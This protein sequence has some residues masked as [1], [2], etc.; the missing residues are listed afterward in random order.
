[1]TTPQSIHGWDEL[2]KIYPSAQEVAEGEHH[3]IYIPEFCLRPNERIEI[4]LCLT[5][6]GGYPTRLYVKNPFPEKGQ[7]WSQKYIRG[8]NWHTF[9]YGGVNNT[10]PLMDILTNHAKVLR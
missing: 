1:M 7:N 6:D 10:L 5:Q 8:E 2:Q 4:L 3:Y 9:S